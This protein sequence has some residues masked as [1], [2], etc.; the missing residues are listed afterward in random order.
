VPIEE[1]LLAHPEV[2]GAAVVGAPDP[3]SGEVPVGYVTLRAGAPVTEDELLAWAAQHAPEPAAAPKAVR[4]L[5]ALP[6]T[7]VRKIFKPELV[8]DAVRR[9]VLTELERAGLT[10]TVEVGTSEGKVIAVIDTTGDTATLTAEL[11]RFS[12]GYAFKNAARS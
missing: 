2:T 6:V 9:T 3:H 11:D 8:Q 4:I 1:S 5:G 10:G 7:A 12:F